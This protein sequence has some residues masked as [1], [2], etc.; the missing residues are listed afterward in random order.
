MGECNEDNAPDNE[1]SHCSLWR[2]DSVV[3]GQEG[4]LDCRCHGQVDVLSNGEELNSPC[5]NI[6]MPR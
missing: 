5:Q 6:P 3:E 1:I 4:E 2:E